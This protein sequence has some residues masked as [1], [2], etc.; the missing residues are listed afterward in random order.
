MQYVLQTLTGM[1]ERLAKLEE[2][3]SNQGKDNDASSLKIAETGAS[4][5]QLN[6][7]LGQLSSLDKQSAYRVYFWPIRVYF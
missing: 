5:F 7:M 4:N 2:S 3:K 6:L 1:E